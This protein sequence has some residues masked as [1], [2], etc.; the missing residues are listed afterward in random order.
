MAVK[1]NKGT[2]ISTLSLTPLIDVV[3]LLLIFFLVATRFA[4]ED[5]E[6]DVPLPDASEA[7]P[8]TIAPKELFINIDQDGK[9]LVNGQILDA[10]EL[11]EVLVRAVTNNPVNQSVVIRSHK[12]AA[13]EYT[14]TAI[15]L[16]KRAGIRD[17]M[18]NTIGEGG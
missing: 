6:I 5:R 14:V 11:E 8:L 12:R 13:V 10:D 3:F 1:I 16:C 17:Y 18:M 9:F 15:N 4:Q 7:M 2:A